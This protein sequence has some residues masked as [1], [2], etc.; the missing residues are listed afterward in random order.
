MATVHQQF[1]G[2]HEQVNE[3]GLELERKQKNKRGGH[4]VIR[5]VWMEMYDPKQHSRVRIRRLMARLPEA[6][7][8]LLETKTRLGDERETPLHVGAL[9]THTSALR[10]GLY[11]PS[12]RGA[13]SMTMRGALTHKS[14]D[15]ITCILTP[16]NAMP[17]RE[18]ARPG[19]ADVIRRRTETTELPAN[20]AGRVEAVGELIAHRLDVIGQVLEGR[21]ASQVFQWHRRD[22]GY[23]F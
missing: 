22:S 23:S 4:R 16:D 3:L 11:I 1:L 15:E 20:L 21:A 8:I 5:S 2:F 6:T 12:G 7:V 18:H 9:A 17:D 19:G 10:G 13:H 14:R